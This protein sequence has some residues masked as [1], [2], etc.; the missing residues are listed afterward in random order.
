MFKNLIFVSLLATSLVAECAHAEKVK[1]AKYTREPI[2][3]RDRYSE[4]PRGAIAR[5]MEVKPARRKAFAFG[6]CL[7][8]KDAKEL[9]SL[10]LVSY[11]KEDSGDS[12]TGSPVTSAP[13][14][15]ENERDREDWIHER[16]FISTLV[17]KNA[18]DRRS[19]PIVE[20]A[21]KKKYK[22]AFLVMGFNPVTKKTWVEKVDWSDPRELRPDESI[23]M[24][25]ERV[26]CSS[27]CMNPL[28]EVD[29][30]SEQG[31]NPSS[32]DLSGPKPTTVEDEKPEEKKSESQRHKSRRNRTS[33]PKG[34]D[35][36]S[37]DTSVSSDEPVT[38]GTSGCNGHRMPC[39]QYVVR[40]RGQCISTHD[41]GMKFNC[42]Y[43]WQTHAS[44]CAGCR[45]ALGVSSGNQ[46]GSGSGEYHIRRGTYY[47]R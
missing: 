12:V 36:G 5:L 6:V 13:K 42:R 34:D 3:E 15:S 11:F 27:Q 24:L 21:C 30:I 41:S 47:V 14:K 35:G 22:E 17:P 38:S 43:A 23:Y 18:K 1:G 29:E 9:G 33:E 2:L 7:A 40:H 20:K 16:E 26:I 28:E 25:G 8:Q 44:G 45:A 4:L 46:S 10:L 37:D 39:G 19:D 32:K 31:F